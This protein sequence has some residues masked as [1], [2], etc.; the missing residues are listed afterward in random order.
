[1]LTRPGDLV[2][3][4]P[5]VYPPFFDWVAE[6]GARLLEVPLSCDETGWRLDLAALEAGKHVL[7]EKPF[8]SNARE[9]MEMADAANS[10]LPPQQRLPAAQAQVR[11]KQAEQVVSEIEC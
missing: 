1:M 5:P 6:A 9:A 4:S 8:A 10:F 11:E 2:A 7:C 3:F